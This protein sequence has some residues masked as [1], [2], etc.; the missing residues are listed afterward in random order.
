MTYN[1]FSITLYA[2]GRVKV[3]FGNSQFVFVRNLDLDIEGTIYFVKYSKLY[4][5]QS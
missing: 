1:L 2:V 4:A 5:L 3:T